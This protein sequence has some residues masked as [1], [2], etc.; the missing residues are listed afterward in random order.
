MFVTVPVCLLWSLIFVVWAT[1]P[2]LNCFDM[3]W[4]VSCNRFHLIS[5][6]L[7]SFDTVLC[8]ALSLHV[9]YKSVSLCGSS[10][11]DLFKLKTVLTEWCV[12][13]VDV[14]SLYFVDVVCFFSVCPSVCLWLWVCFCV[15]SFNGPC[16]LKINDLIRFDYWN[17]SKAKHY[18]FVSVHHLCVLILRFPFM[19]CKGKTWK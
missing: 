13:A 11:V 3:I 10:I 5:F 16:C 9:F 2:E 17:S 18:V 6:D 4:I 15:L 14:V 19:P 12:S 7:P 1:L 8:N